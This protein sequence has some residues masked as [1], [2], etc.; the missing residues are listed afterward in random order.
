MPSLS[1][2][3]KFLAV[4]GKFILLVFLA[5]LAKERIDVISVVV[6]D[7][8]WSD[9]LPLFQLALHLPLFWTGVLVPVALVSALWSAADVLALAA[10]PD[11]AAAGFLVLLKR[12][13]YKLLLAAMMALTL[14]PSL[15]N[16]ILGGPHRLVYQDSSNYLIIAGIGIALI[17]WFGRRPKV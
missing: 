12:V 2:V 10:A 3:L 15:E 8:G 4:A 5:A 1:S 17:A 13:G 7:R 9:V 14:V 6:R 16:S 11:R